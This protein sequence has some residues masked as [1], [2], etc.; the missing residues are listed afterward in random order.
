MTPHFHSLVPDGVFVPRGGAACASRRCPRPRRDDHRG[1]GRGAALA[2]HPG[3]LLPSAAPHPRGPHRRGNALRP[4]PL[5]GGS[6]AGAVE[7]FSRMSHFRA[8][9]LHRR[10][11]PS[12]HWWNWSRSTR[13]AGWGSSPA[14][15]CAPEGGGCPDVMCE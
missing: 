8:S 14:S 15:F 4:G 12:P 3:P 10:S 1:P 9:P 11:C 5:R 7:P 6:G 2:L 13:C